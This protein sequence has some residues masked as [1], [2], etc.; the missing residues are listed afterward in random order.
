MRGAPLLAL[1][2]VAVIVGGGYWYWQ[3]QT[4]RAVPKGLAV[5]N[6]R[7]EVEHVEI[8]AKLPGRIAEIRVVEGDFVTKGAVIARLDTAELRAQLAAA[9]AAIERASAS[10]ARAE[11]DIAIRE[12]ELDLAEIEMRRASNLAQS[13]GGSKAEVERRTAQYQVAKAQV[14]GARSALADAKAAKLVAEA[15]VAQIKATIDDTI[16]YTPVTGRVEYKLM[17]AGEVVAAGGRVATVLD[18]SNAYMT[19]FLPTS[20]TGRVALG[21]EARIVLDA[22]PAYVFPASV[23]FIAGEAQFTPKTVET[24]TER[25]KLMYRLKVSVDP[26]L[27]VTYQDYVKAGLTG[28]AYIK[29]APDAV[30]PA[31]LT[32]R[33]PDVAQ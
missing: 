2:S 24:A 31:F 27:L 8:A 11:A 6:G 5:A 26:K 1:V 13:A 4:A 25:E 22:I 28:N 7:V 23:S 15:Q 16:L 33:L 3:Q 18:L 9:E 29:V 20:A 12:A 32:P 21:S 14:L 17:Q 10:I 30:W 19:I